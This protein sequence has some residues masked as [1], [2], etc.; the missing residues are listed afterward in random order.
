[1]VIAQQ[2]AP[3]AREGTVGS[4]VLEL[5]NVSKHY[6]GFSAVEDASLAMRR[7]EILT[8]LGPSG[9]GKSTMLRMIAGLERATMGEI[10]IDGR[11]VDSDSH[12]N[13]V[14]AGKRNIGMVFQSRAIWPHMTVADNVAYPLKVRGVGLPEIR[15]RVSHLLEVVGLGGIEQ[16]P[17]PML[18]EGQQ[19]WVSI[20]RILVFEPDVLLLDEPFSDLHPE[21]REQMRAE[22]RVLQRRLGTAVVFAT[23]DKTD[24]LSVSDRIAVMDH[25]N[26]EQE[27]EPVELYRHPKTAT[28]RDLLGR[29]VT[30][31]GTVEQSGSIDGLA[32]RLH[33]DDGPVV[34]ADTE[35]AEH[36]AA[37]ARCSATI[38]PESIA[39]GPAESSFGEQR[40][41][42]LHGVIS[43]LLFGGDRFGARVQLPW[44]QEIFLYLPPNDGWREGQTVS[45][46]FAP[47]QIQ[48]WPRPAT[49]IR[50]AAESGA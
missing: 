15:D 27:G 41:N 31:E 28:V 1:M 46:W 26:I 4:R 38:R 23:R 17:A 7:G 33:N 19:R 16:L 50:E 9:C 42:S 24:A 10:V 12:T 8:L 37:G 11:V 30:L 36:L 39:V 21:L 2:T 22:I 43:T 13:Y 5:R 40:A 44:R 29:T 35:A 20:A 45:L 32:V 6:G 34:F 48:V 49:P 25:G 18:D 47:D 3:A 14:S